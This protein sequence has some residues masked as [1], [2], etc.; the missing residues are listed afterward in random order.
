MNHIKL[1]IHGYTLLEIMVSLAIFSILAMLTSHVIY[2]AS[3]IESRVTE[4]NDFI[5]KIQFAATFLKQNIREATQRSIYINNMQYLP[6][7]IGDKNFIEF[8]RGGINTQTNIKESSIKRVAFICK[9]QNLIFKSWSVLDAFNRKKF[10]DLVLLTNLKSCKF[11][12]LNHTKQI[13]PNW[14]I[15]Y[16]QQQ[17]QNDKL[18]IGIQ[19]NLEFEDSGKLSLLFPIP[20]ALYST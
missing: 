20:E 2:Q 5:K 1:K 15:A 14:Q 13:L 18:P 12:F 8:S 17:N 7:F 6:S 3:N 4:N 9:D 11:G 16:T 19:L 10:N